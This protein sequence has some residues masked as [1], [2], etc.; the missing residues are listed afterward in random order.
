M[1]LW[2]ADPDFNDQTNILTLPVVT[3]NH[4]A[5]FNNISIFLNPNGTWQIVQVNN[6]PSISG[7]WTARVS[8][9][10][11]SFPPIFCEARTRISI[12]QTGNTITGTGS[13][14]KISPF[15]ETETG[16]LTGIIEGNKIIFS[17]FIRDGGEDQVL[18]YKGDIKN[19]TTELD[20]DDGPHA[21]GWEAKGDSKWEFE[22]S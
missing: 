10:S 20:I 4:Q 18:N 6:A 19:N 15:G 16:N 3:V 2:A 5:S 14:Q 8:D 21:C 1:P 9:I 7:D 22:R 11:E 13:F 12:T 17:L